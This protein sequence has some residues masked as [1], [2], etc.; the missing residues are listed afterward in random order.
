MQLNYLKKPKK[1]FLKFSREEWD[2][3]LAVAPPI[4]TSATYYMAGPEEE[5]G[6]PLYGRYGNP[7]RN[8]VEAVLASL[9][10]AKYSLCFSSGKKAI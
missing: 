5:E 3:S 8:A 10:G 4:T 2:C 6:A 7:S 9:E 1:D